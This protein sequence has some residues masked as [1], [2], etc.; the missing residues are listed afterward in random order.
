MTN[1]TSYLGK[2]I[3]EGGCKVEKGRRDGRDK[4]ISDYLKIGL[5]PNYSPGGK[6]ISE[7]TQRTWGTSQKHLIF[8]SLIINHYLSQVDV[9]RKRNTPELI[10]II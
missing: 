9:Y 4:E 5:T 7:S 2:Y 6:E 10:Y 3:T 1:P 8:F